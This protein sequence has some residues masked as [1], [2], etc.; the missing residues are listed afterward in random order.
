[1]PRIA[2]F[3]A[4]ALLP[5]LVLGDPAPYNIDYGATR[6]RWGRGQLLEKPMATI[7]IATMDG[8]EFGILSSE[9]EGEGHEVLWAS[10][11]QEAVN[12]T[13]TRHPVMVFVDLSLPVYDGFEVAEMLRGDPDVPRDLPVL[14]LCDDAIE[15]HRFDRSGFTAQFP[16][17]HA[18]Q[19]VRELLAQF[20]YLPLPPL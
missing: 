11:G 18:H 17:K 10:D 9:V 19:D 4:I 12:L 8:T 2:S 16:K 3:N 20:A 6:R 13:L 14:A 1:M 15:P 5:G 7:L